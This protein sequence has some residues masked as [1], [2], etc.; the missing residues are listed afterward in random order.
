MFSLL[1]DEYDKRYGIN[2]DHLSRISE[3]ILQM[4][5]KIPTHKH[6][7]G[8]LRVNL[9]HVM[10]NIIQLLRVELEKLIV[11]KLLIIQQLF[12]LQMKVG[13]KNMLK[14]TI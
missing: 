1:T 2:E 11:V 6:A 4:Q 3:L 13:Q 14:I 7:G 5:R 10:I 12:F 8:H 9:S